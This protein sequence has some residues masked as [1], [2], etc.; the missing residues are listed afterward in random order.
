MNCRK[1]RSLLSAYSKGEL[2][3]SMREKLA[4]HLEECPACRKQEATIGQINQALLNLPK[5]ELSEDFNMRLFGRIHNAPNGERIRTAHLPKKAPSG[6][7][8]WGKLFAPAA[9][10][11]GAMVL[12]LTFL[13]PGA[14]IDTAPGLT[15]VTAEVQN[16]TADR[17]YATNYYR[18]A[19]RGFALDRASLD[20]MAMMHRVGYFEQLSRQQKRDFGAYGFD[21]PM[22]RNVSQHGSMR[23]YVL[24]T[25][26]PTNKLIKDATF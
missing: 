9:T 13:V 11:I 26:S 8:Y 3:Y 16:G 21:N 25:V 7:I 17:Q 19:L 18:P 5:H 1:A 22:L 20:S 6:I 24:P 14:T 23:H 15:P 4:A 10:V 12:T 2:S